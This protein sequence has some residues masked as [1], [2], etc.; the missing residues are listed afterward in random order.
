MLRNCLSA[1]VCWI[2]TS[3]G[4]V[5]V[6][7]PRDDERDNLSFDG[8]PW[9]GVADGHRASFLGLESRNPNLV[10]KPGGRQLHHPMGHHLERWADMKVWAHRS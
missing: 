2:V 7:Q 10:R 6:F 8:V 1:L 9:G 3:V 5:P 4:I